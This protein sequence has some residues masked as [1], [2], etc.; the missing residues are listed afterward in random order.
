M[1][2][3][4]T[5]PYDHLTQY[6]HATEEQMQQ[7]LLKNQ[8]GDFPLRNIVNDAYH[9]DIELPSGICNE[10]YSYLFDNSGIEHSYFLERMFYDY[11][12][13]LNKINKIKQ[14]YLLPLCI[15][16]MEFI[17]VI[18][19]SFC[20][21]NIHDDN[22]T[23]RKLMVDINNY[24]LSVV[25]F[26]HMILI[27]SSL[28]TLTKIKLN[29]ELQTAKAS[30]DLC[31]NDTELNQMTHTHINTNSTKSAHNSAICHN[32]LLLL[33]LIYQ[34][35]P[36]NYMEAFDSIQISLIPIYFVTMLL[37]NIFVYRYPND[38]PTNI[39]SLV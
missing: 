36:F 30:V 12:Y 1:D 26:V 27:I 37:F 6:Q 33:P 17:C 3:K 7:H 24:V 14:T 16:S 20:F 28:K 31:L 32:K 2:F 10:I 23:D 5:F 34:W 38:L 18:M 19:Y 13:S 35:V 21:I 15:Q 4:C 8:F 39:L 11:F 25:I 29:I 9:N 22:R